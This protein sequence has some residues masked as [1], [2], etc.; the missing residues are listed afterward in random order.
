V[1]RIYSQENVKFLHLV[2]GVKDTQPGRYQIFTLKVKCQGS[3]VGKMSN[4]HIQGEVTRIH[5]G[6]C[7]TF[8]IGVVSRIHGKR[9]SNTHTSESVKDRQSER[10]VKYSEAMCGVKDIHPERCWI[11]TF[12][13]NC[14]DTK[15]G[16]VSYI[17]SAISVGVKDIQLAM[18]NIYSLHKVSGIHNQ[19]CQILMIGVN[20]IILL[21]RLSEKC[22]TECMRYSLHIIDLRSSINLVKFFEVCSISPH[23]ALH[24]WG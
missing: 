23:I 21:F 9:M 5:N 16:R 22:P 12:I 11:F 7:Q 3:K 24:S 17:Y 20:I 8:T 14:Q 4:I 6:I 19:E 15:V 13:V 1:S 18:S 10:G 2:G